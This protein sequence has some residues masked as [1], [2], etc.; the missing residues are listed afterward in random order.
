M[1]SMGWH[2][3]GT[4]ALPPWHPTSTG[5]HRS[6]V[7]PLVNRAPS[8]ETSSL[9]AFKAVESLLI[10]TAP[11]QLQPPT[12]NHD[13]LLTRYSSL[14]S[15]LQLYCTLLATYLILGF[16]PLTLL[17]FLSLITKKHYQLIKHLVCGSTLR[18]YNPILLFT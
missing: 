17:P 10:P 4:P 9:N 15:C 13:L 5:F 14:Y 12:N 3:G 16:Q 2:Q 11:E 6:T 1:G 18:G 7:Y 8:F